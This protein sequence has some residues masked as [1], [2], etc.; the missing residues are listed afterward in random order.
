MSSNAL[1]LSDSFS[2][3]LN[4]KLLPQKNRL[5]NVHAKDFI[6]YT[7]FSK[8]KYDNGVISCILIIVVVL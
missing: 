4:N 3:D 8:N 7:D 2:F 5:L 6:P 1:P